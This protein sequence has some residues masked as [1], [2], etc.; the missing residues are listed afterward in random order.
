MWSSDGDTPPETITCPFC[1]LLC[2]DLPLEWL[3]KGQPDNPVTGC[4]LAEQSYRDAWDEPSCGVA[5]KGKPATLQQAIET[6][7]EFLRKSESP[8]FAGLATDVN[9]MRSVLRLADRCGAH[10]D[11]SN[12]DAL[13]RNLRVLQ[14]SGWFTTTFGEV[15][16][17]ADL[18]ILVGV[19]CLTHFP[20]IEERVL[21][22]DEALFSQPGSRRLVLIGS[23]QEVMLPPRLAALDPLI[24]PLELSQ[25]GNFSGLLRGLLANRPVR[26]N[27]LGATIEAQLPALLEMLRSA[28][29]SVFCWSAAELAFAHAELSVDTLVQLVRDLNR[30]S[31]S[32]ALPMGGT[33][34]DQT[35]NQVCTWQTGYPLR[36][37]LQR[38]YPQHD[39]LLYRYQDL[40][41]RNDVDLLLW[42]SSLSAH[43]RPPATSLPSIVLGHPGM[44]LATPP[45]VF[46][47]VGIPGIDHPGHLYRSDTS[48]V[49]P[50]TKLRDI[51]LPSVA[52]VLSTLHDRLPADYVN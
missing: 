4:P 30:E 38:G 42:V 41:E 16:N 23:W 34:G 27:A 51:G 35:A 18:L 12:S 46:I 1:G 21:L 10:L 45:D 24:I 13:F 11:H 48:C 43:M 44:T 40:L 8:L 20:R 31:R 22:P 37:S 29:Y 32:A 5:L 6:C 19:E 2:D 17:R 14:D 52:S 7:G 9:G 33:L 28:H 3:D 36:S 50:L 47:P 26:A 15:R 25:L 39:P 49:L